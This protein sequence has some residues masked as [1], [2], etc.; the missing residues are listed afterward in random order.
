MYNIFINFEHFKN[1]IKNTQNMTATL[2]GTMGL[3]TTSL[4]SPRD[5]IEWLRTKWLPQN[6]LYGKMF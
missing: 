4:C 6:I 1:G 3:N 2:P 5:M